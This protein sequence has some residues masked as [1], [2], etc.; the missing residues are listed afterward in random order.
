MSL[1]ELKHALR[2]ELSLSMM[3]VRMLMAHMDI[4]RNGQ[5][6]YAEFLHFIHNSGRGVDSP[7]N[8]A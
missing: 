7:W 5:V 6:D 1:Q 2:A 4:D 8:S 3:D